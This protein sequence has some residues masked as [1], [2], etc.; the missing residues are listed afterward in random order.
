M[1][2]VTRS[3]HQAFPVN[4]ALVSALSVEESKV[5]HDF[6]S[7]EG[8]AATDWLLL[9]KLEEKP[10]GEPFKMVAPMGKDEPIVI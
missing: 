4:D 2:A 1:L 3:H 7:V 10:L 9:V 5:C 8:M 6:S